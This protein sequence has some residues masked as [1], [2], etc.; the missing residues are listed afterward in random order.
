MKKKFI[1]AQSVA[2]EQFIFRRKKFSHADR[3]DNKIHI[4]LTCG[5]YRTFVFDNEDQ[6]ERSFE[7]LAKTIGILR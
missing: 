2:G 5:Y 7:A 6:A 1:Y 3:E 4:F